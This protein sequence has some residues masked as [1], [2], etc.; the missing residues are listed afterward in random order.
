MLLPGIL[1]MSL[2]FK[3]QALSVD[4]WRERDQGTLRRAACT[5]ASVGALLAGKLLAAGIVILASTVFLLVV[6][7]LYLQT[8]LG[9]LPLAALWGAAAGVVF[10]EFF[11]VMQMH[12][13]SQ[14]AG[15]LLTNSIVMPLLFMGGSFF[16]FEAM[17]QWMSTIGKRTPN[18]WALLQFKEILA[19]RVNASAVSF[20][21]AGLVAVAAVLFFFS[22]RRMRRVFA[23]S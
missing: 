23:R 12:A 8:P 20:A 2:L 17:P 1:F 19:G 3:G 10:F 16:P 5:P 9:P 22:E 21:F 18:G 13:T 4:M 6:G 11:T 14:R 15:M 7:M